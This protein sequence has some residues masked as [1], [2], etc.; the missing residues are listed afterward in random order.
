MSITLNGNEKKGTR[1]KDPENQREGGWLT[2]SKRKVLTTL[3]LLERRVI[4]VLV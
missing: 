2:E 4:L 3:E 1:K